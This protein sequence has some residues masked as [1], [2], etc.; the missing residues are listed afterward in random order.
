VSFPMRS[1]FTIAEI[2]ET[3]G[4][5]QK[6]LDAAISEGNKKAISA[7]V[8]VIADLDSCVKHAADGYNKGED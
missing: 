7:L 2:K 5:Y 8:Q 3:I 6:M 4:E 1:K